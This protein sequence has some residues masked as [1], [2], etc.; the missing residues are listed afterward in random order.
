[1]DALYHR[2]DIL[3]ACGPDP[4][5]V[6]ID[7]LHGYAQDSETIEFLAKRRLPSDVTSVVASLLGHAAWRAGSLDAL[8]GLFRIGIR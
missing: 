7:R 6:D 8:E 3:K 1:M 4:M 5:L 2:Y